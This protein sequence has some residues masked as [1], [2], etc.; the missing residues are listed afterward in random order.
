[1]WSWLVEL[2]L[3]WVLPWLT[4]PWTRIWMYLIAFYVT[5][6]LFSIWSNRF[7]VRATGVREATYKQSLIAKGIDIALLALALVL[8]VPWFITI[9]LMLLAQVGVFAFIFKAPIGKAIVATILSWTMAG[10]F[11]AIYLVLLGLY[12]WFFRSLPYFA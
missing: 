7:A 8:P 12:I 2:F 11:T 1:M 5:Y 10:M 4:I 9:P 6:S 3:K